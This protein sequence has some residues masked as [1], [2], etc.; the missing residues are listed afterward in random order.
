ML[1]KCCSPKAGPM[2]M[3]GSELKKVYK[4]TKEHTWRLVLI[5]RPND[6]PQFKLECVYPPLTRIII[7]QIIVC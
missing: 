5:K 1:L 3:N 2:Q 4:A 7:T 6:L